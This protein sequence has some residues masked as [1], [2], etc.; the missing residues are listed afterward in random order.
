MVNCQLFKY[1]KDFYSIKKDSAEFF[2]WKR[3]WLKK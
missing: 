1:N 3:G 2:F